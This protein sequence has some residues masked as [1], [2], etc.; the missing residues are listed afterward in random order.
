MAMNFLISGSDNSTPSNSVDNFNFICASFPSTWSAT[1]TD[2]DCPVAGAMTLTEMYVETLD[3]PGAGNSFVFTV[4]KNGSATALVVT[5][6]DSAN[7]GSVTGQAVTFAAG[8]TISMRHTPVSTPD[9]SGQQHWGILAKTSN[10]T[11]V[12]FGHTATNASTT[13]TEWQ[14]L[15]GG[16]GVWEAVAQSNVMQIAPL[17]GT[18]RD[19]YVRLGT[20]PGTATSR[21]FSVLLGGSAA[22]APT[23]T[24]ADT[25]TAGQDT[26]TTL[27]FGAA[28]TL[29]FQSAV[30]LVPAASPVAWSIVCI[31]TTAGESMILFGNSNPPLVSGTEWEQLQGGGAGTWAAFEDIRGMILAGGTAKSIYV[32]IGT[33]ADNGAGVQ[34]WTFTLRKELAD[35]ALAVTI[36]E[37]ASKA[38]F[39]TDVTITPGDTIDWQCVP[40][41]TPAAMTGGAHLGLKIFF[42]PTGSAKDVIRASSVVPFQR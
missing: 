21:T 23:V 31:P 12:M 11:F 38:N 42:T 29:S 6:S 2:R 17:A 30:T 35:T 28:D 26:T 40:A 41:N 39:S 7:T 3:P 20:A 36:S 25:A 15:Q 27:A 8:D 5:I 19:L 37:A 33:P 24:I 10:N 32:Q 18:L 34:S 13:A 9:A 22:G 16:I 1:E 14:G 4:M